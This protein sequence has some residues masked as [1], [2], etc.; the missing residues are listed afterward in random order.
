M[1]LFYYAQYYYG[2][3]ILHN[4][5]FIITI[6]I[7]VMINVKNYVQVLH[8]MNHNMYWNAKLFITE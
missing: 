8:I 7:I 2:L 3:F 1:V 4:V 5:V 6:V